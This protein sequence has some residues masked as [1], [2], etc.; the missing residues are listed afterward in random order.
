MKI[1][2]RALVIDVEEMSVCLERGEKILS[3]T[4]HVGIDAHGCSYYCAVTNAHENA[5][6]RSKITDCTH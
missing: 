3:I 6:K 2:T 5:T 4:V 1:T